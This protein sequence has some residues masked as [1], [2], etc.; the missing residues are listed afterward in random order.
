MGKFKRFVDDN[1]LKDLFLHGRKFTWSNERETTTLTK[2]DRAFVSVDWELDHPECLLQALSTEHSDH[3]PLHLALEEH[4]H[5]RRSFRFEKFWVKMDG[6]LDVVKEAWVCDPDITDPFFC[7]DIMLR[8]TARALATW[9]QKE[10]GN[11]KLQ[12]AIANIVIMRFDC[13]QESRSLTEFERWL[14]R[15]LKQLVLGLASPERTIARQ[16]SRIT[17]LQEGDANT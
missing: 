2:I 1:A 3:C 8:N 13:A 14:R 15:T 9:G 10:I 16:R 7:L 6:F 4:M 17:W 5:A 12:I 11:M